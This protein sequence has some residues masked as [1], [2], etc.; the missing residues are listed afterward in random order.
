MSNFCQ[1]VII[2]VYKIFEYGGV[3]KS[4]EHFLGG[5]GGYE[6][7]TVGH[8]GGGGYLKCSREH[9]YCENYVHSTGNL[10]VWTPNFS[11]T[12]IETA[13]NEKS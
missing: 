5:G 8:V 2:S 4:R 13:V 6:L 7:L 12:R 9:F 11:V 1:L 3:H 10:D